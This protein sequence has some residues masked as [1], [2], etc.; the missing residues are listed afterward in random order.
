MLS[1]GNSIMDHFHR[2]GSPGTKWSKFTNGFYSCLKP[3]V[4]LLQGSSLT[5]RPSPKNGIDIIWYCT[6]QCYVL[7]PVPR[8]WAIMGQ[9]GDLTNYCSLAK[10]Q[11]W[12]EHL[13]NLSKRA[14]YTMP[15]V[16]W[17]YSGC[18]AIRPWLWTCVYINVCL[19]ICFGGI[20][21]L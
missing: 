16:A 17:C 11:P 14:S 5:P 19:I 21:S 4:T 2:L 9:G 18:C 1:V 6:Y 15:I 10:E 20:K 3:L 8:V 7:L 13:T 12:A